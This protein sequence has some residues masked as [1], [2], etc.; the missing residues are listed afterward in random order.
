[1]TDHVGM[2][3]YIYNTVGRYSNPVDNPYYFKENI[4]VLIQS[5]SWEQVDNMKE[6]EAWAFLTDQINLCTNSFYCKD[7]KLKRKVSRSLNGLITVLWC[8][9]DKEQKTCLKAFYPQP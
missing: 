9:Q 1:M 8:W 6:E 7:T 4:N 3:F 5:V 2:V